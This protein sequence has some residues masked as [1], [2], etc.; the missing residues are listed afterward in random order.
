MSKNYDLSN[1]PVKIDNDVPGVVIVCYFRK[2]DRIA[3]N[4][5][6][7]KAYIKVY[8]KYTEKLE[9]NIDSE[10]KIVN[11]HHKKWDELIPFL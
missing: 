5:T 7:L 2:G 11:Y 9:R 3:P 8:L 1:G 6:G 10:S 4:L